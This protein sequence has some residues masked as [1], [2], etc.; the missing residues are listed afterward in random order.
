MNAPALATTLH[1]Y[2]R[3]RLHHVNASE[4]DMIAA[5]HASTPLEPGVVWALTQRKGA[6]SPEDTFKAAPDLWGI[7]VV[8]DTTVITYLRLGMIQRSI[9][10]GESLPEANTV[11]RL[12]PAAGERL[13]AS[14]A[15]GRTFGRE[16][17]LQ[18]AQ[19]A[20]TMHMRR[21]DAKRARKAATKERDKLLEENKRLTK[22]RNKLRAE[23]E[24]LR[25]RLRRI[26]RAFTFPNGQEP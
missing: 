12:A 6:P 15:C 13:A 10:T 7:F 1:A 3:Y 11:R 16:E 21:L 2:D 24:E 18:V 26:K 20:Q 19:F 8:K 22:E 4:A 5:V 25:A 23:N 14:L 9:L 17:V